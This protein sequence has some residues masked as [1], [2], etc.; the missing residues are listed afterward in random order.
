MYSTRP[1][2][3]QQEDWV[4]IKNDQVSHFK[5]LKEALTLRGGSLM[6]LSYYEKHYK[7]IHDES[8]LSR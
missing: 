7:P 4:V 6:P 5:T 8:N 2:L 1:N 3:A